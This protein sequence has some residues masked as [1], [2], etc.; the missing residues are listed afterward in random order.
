MTQSDT[1][2]M[3]PIDAVRV[4]SGAEPAESNTTTNGATPTLSPYTPDH[5]YESMALIS[6]EMNNEHR[7]LADTRARMQSGNSFY[8][9]AGGALGG[10][11]SLA[12]FAN[13]R[14]EFSNLVK[15][16]VDKITKLV[17]EQADPVRLVRSIKAIDASSLDNTQRNKKIA[18]EAIS[19]KNFFF[20]DTVDKGTFETLEQI[21][22]DILEGKEPSNLAENIEQREGHTKEIIGRMK[23]ALTTYNIFGSEKKTDYT[24]RIERQF[25]NHIENKLNTLGLTENSLKEVK[26]FFIRSISETGQVRP[27]AIR[28]VLEKELAHNMHKPGWQAGLGAGAI[29][30][31]A[32]LGNIAYRFMSGDK[33][34]QIRNSEE[35]LD[36]LGDAFDLYNNTPYTQIAA[37]EETTREPLDAAAQE[38]TASHSV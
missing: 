22:K 8:Q 21:V 17:S 27:V 10:V 32:G 14:Q 5:D 35:K 36:Q 9:M 20:N 19:L 1:P 12:F 29:I 7:Q 33:T 18:G 25:S 6:Q 34:Q 30:V 31:G 2:N 3:L 37:G 13:K 38:Q 28:D 26:S 23:E 15:G 24:T 4:A 16:K 11:G